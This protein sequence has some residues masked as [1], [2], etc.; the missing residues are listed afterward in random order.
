LRQISAGKFVLASSQRKNTGL[1]LLFGG[2]A[3]DVWC[4]N[5]PGESLRPSRFLVRFL[6]QYLP[7]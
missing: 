4:K 6:V 1:S 7:G 3:D 2:I 5:V